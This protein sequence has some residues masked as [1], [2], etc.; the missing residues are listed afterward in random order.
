ATPQQVTACAAA[1]T[2]LA[3]CDTQYQAALQNAFNAATASLSTAQR[4]ALTNIRANKDWD[5]PTE[6]LLVNRPEAQWVLLRS[7]LANERIA[8]AAGQPASADAQAALNTF[9]SQTQVA[10]A[11][12]ALD[13]N[14][15]AT[16][17]AWNQALGQ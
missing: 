14:L 5:V 9:R 7:A 8:A 1:G 6:F 17:T 11:K 3:Q 12:A 10:A 15:A 16:T 4:T 13:A 2:L